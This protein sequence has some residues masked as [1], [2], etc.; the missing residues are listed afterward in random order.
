MDTI[1]AVIGAFLCVLGLAAIAFFISFAD[2][3]SFNFF[4]PK[5][6]ASRRATFEQSNAYNAGMIRD[7]ENIQMEYMN[8]DE[9]HK[10]ALKAIVLHRFSV[11]PESQMPAN[12][13]SFY[14]SL[15]G[16]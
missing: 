8:A 4:S 16:N 7:L 10:S 15:K 13:R 3:A 5:Y 1:K 6:E 11:Y 14:Y 12:L 9:A 2:W